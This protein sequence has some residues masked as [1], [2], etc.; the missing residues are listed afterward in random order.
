MTDK[1]HLD[2]Q[3]RLFL[4]Y[5]LLVTLA[6][7]MQSVAVAWHVYNQTHSALHLG[8]V[9]LAIFIPNLIF[10]LPGGRAADRYPRRR[11]MIMSIATLLGASISL[12]WIRHLL[13][14]PL[15]TV[16]T[17]LSLVGLARAYYGPAASA[18]LP[19]LVGAEKLPQAVAL[20][21]TIFQF[22]TIL[23][24]ALAGG[25]VAIPGASVSTVY[26]CCTVLFC[27]ALVAL[28][29]LPALS[30]PGGPRR[31]LEL[32][33]GLRYVA[34]NKL[35]F[36]AIS[37]DLFAVL[38]GGAV[39][40]LPIF[41][42]D[43]LQVGAPGLGAMRSAPAAGATLMALYLAWKPLHKKVGYKMLAAVL[44]FGLVTI[45]FGLS[46]NFVLSLV[47]L[48]VLGASDMISVV[49]RQ[50]LIQTHTPD[51]MRGRVSAVNMVFIGASNELGEFE[52]G[53]TAAWLGTIPA[54][55]LGGL[56]TC[57]VVL[58]W[59]Y[60]FPSLRKADHLSPPT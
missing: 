12:F 42:R 28:L 37:L 26:A 40:L 34:Q 5:R 56:G 41:A 13:N 35:I 15:W 45:V 38:L 54:V 1:I 55:V 51:V 33:G 48:V 57:L 25:L 52:S 47:C 43:I 46:K 53:L 11:I 17:T 60:A 10:A 9:G 20:N 39:A 6:I 18:F 29:R 50:T 36:G 21:S 30:M 2:P 31:K 7:Q 14:P 32:L 44:V 16:Y 27:C 3:F 58:I 22:S 4:L 19:Q 24:P 8:Y 59:A 49:V 23:G